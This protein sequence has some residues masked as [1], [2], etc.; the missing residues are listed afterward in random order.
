MFKLILV[1][2]LLTLV[3]S[4]EEIKRTIFVLFRGATKND[5]RGYYA[6]RI[7]QMVGTLIML[8]AVP[9]GL[10][11]LLASEGS[12]LPRLGWLALILLVISLLATGTGIF[13]RRMRMARGT[14]GAEKM[15]PIAFAVLGLFSPLFQSVNN[16]SGLPR[17]VIGKFAFTLALPPLA[18]FVIKSVND[19]VVTEAALL[20]HLD[21]LTILLVVALI[22]QI[23][24]EFLRQFFRAYRLE[25][26]FSYFR[27]ILG[28]CL[29]TV[30]LVG[31]A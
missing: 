5:T 21:A 31:L 18:G 20:P 22:I 15:I 24:A 9:I 14:E 6:Y 25:K 30:M 27:V 19:S 10:T 3:Y 2:I 29:I 7:D 13:V 11:W 4:W 8:A 17:S 12:L 23:T 28:I 1:S 26:F 16:F